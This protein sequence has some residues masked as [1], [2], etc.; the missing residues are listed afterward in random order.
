MT[1]RDLLQSGFRY[2][3][4]LTH[5]EHE[6]EDL[7]QDVWLK[8]Y[9]NSGEIK[10]KSLF[11]TSIRNLFIDRYRKKKLVVIEQLEEIGETEILTSEIDIND[12][13]KCLAKLR[14][15]EREALFLNSV[16]EYTA[17]EISELTN[18]PR[19]TVLSLISRGKKKFISAYNHLMNPKMRNHSS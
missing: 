7:V 8:L 1:D 14:P 11:F 4:S 3:L 9:I 6:A 2:A 15:E 17:K 19:S 16:E 18:Q 13:E 10:S 12:I 5:N